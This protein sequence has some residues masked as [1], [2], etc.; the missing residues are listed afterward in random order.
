MGHVY[1]AAC[2]MYSLPSQSFRVMIDWRCLNT[3]PSYLQCLHV[4][5]GRPVRFSGPGAAVGPLM[6]V[7]VSGQ[8]SSGTYR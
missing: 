3:R 7:C 6:C 4:L 8:L 2:N 5:Y 1:S